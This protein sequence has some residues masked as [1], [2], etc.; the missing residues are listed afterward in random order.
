[1]PGVVPASWGTKSVRAHPEQDSCRTSAH[2][3]I[4]RAKVVGDWA[5]IPDAISALSLSYW[6]SVS[7]FRCMVSFNLVSASCACAATW[8]LAT[9]MCAATWCL[10]TGMCTHAKRVDG[11]RSCSD[12]AGHQSLHTLSNVVSNLTTC[13]TTPYQICQGLG[14]SQP[15][16]RGST[17]THQ[18][19]VGRGTNDHSRTGLGM[20]GAKG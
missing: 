16:T 12:S 2:P 13:Q 7:S 3:H 19:R 18:S 1:M 15:R 11:D 6:Y 5:N 8:C 14:M 10:A 17:Y 20:K 9:R 4:R